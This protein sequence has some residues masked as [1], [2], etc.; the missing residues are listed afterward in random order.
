MSERSCPECGAELSAAD[1]TCDACGEPLPFEPGEPGVACRVC[2]AEIDAYAETCPE[3]GEK[4]YPALRP[5]TGKHFKGSPASEDAR[6]R[7]EAG[8]E[9]GDP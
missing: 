6:E 3:C 4:G 8:T 1:Q 5:R 7:S 9:A 2:G